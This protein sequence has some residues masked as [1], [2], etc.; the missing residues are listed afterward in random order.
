V[1]VTRSGTFAWQ[2]LAERELRALEDTSPR[3]LPA[4]ALAHGLAALTCA[5]LALR[6]TCQD[7]TGDV[8]STLAGIGSTLEDISGAAAG[9]AACTSLIAGTADAPGWWQRLT[10]RYRRGRLAGLDAATAATA[11]VL[12]DPDATPADRLAAATAEEAVFTAFARTPG[13]PEILKAGI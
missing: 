12:A 8:S 13:G 10:R 4:Q 5:V 1:T 9:T 2:A 7:Q 11:A 6:E 3:E